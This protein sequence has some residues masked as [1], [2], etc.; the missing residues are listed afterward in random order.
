MRKKVEKY[1]DGGGMFYCLGLIG[2]LVYFIK[3]A[4]SFGD[5]LYGVVKAIVWPAIVAFKLLES[6]AL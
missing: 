4:S 3:N 5:A 6:F 1:S 2:A